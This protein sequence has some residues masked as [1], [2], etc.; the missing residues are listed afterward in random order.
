MSYDFALLPRDP[1]Q[2]RHQVMEASE[3]L[4]L[5][6]G[7]RRLSL[8]ARKRLERIASRLQAHDSQLERVTTGRYIEL[9]RVDDTGIQVSLLAG[10]L[11][12][13]VAYWHTGPPA[14]R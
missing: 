3:R 9:T 13:A 4:A 1:G 14:G 10:E 2:S 12:V 11:A 5:E 8:A 7:D 6:E